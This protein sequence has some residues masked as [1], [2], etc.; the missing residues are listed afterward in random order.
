[1]SEEIAESAFVSARLLGY[2]LWPEP[3]T[4]GKSA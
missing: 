2:E 1:M 4:R 3:W